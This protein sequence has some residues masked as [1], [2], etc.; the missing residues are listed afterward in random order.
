MGPVRGHI[1][2][3]LAE[4]TMK[5]TEPDAPLISEILLIVSVVHSLLHNF[6]LTDYVFILLAMVMI[7]R[8]PRLSLE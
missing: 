4:Q 8:A 3:S 7:H 1:V 5:C 2:C 6:P